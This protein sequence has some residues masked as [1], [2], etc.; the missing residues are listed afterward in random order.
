MVVV[1]LVAEYQSSSRISGSDSKSTM[2]RWW[3]GGGIE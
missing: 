1:V 2:A 3:Q